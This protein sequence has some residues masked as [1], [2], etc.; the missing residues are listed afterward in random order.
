[1]LENITLKVRGE[2]HKKLTIHVFLQNRK[3][4]IKPWNSGIYKAFISLT[5]FVI[6]LKNSEKLHKNSLLGQKIVLY[7]LT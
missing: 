1:M 4:L 7:Y 3:V 5:S 6:K 2:F